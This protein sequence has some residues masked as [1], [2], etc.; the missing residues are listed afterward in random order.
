MR[1]EL[2]PSSLGEILDRTAQM[3]RGHF[4]VYFGIAAVSYAGVLVV[5]L[6]AYTILFAH[7]AG[8]GKQFT[9]DTLFV[10]LGIGLISI[11]P[12]AIGMAAV[13][14]AVASNYLGQT[15]TI[16]QAYSSIRRRWYRYILILVAMYCYAILPA[17]LAMVVTAIPIGVMHTG[18]GR[19]LFIGLM[20]VVVLIGFCAAFWWMLRWALAVPASLMEELAVHRSLK[21]SAMLTKGARGRIFVML[22][23]VVA[24]V[25]VIQYAV[26]I[27]MFFLLF[28]NK[29]AITLATQVVASCGTFLSGSF[30]LPIYSIALTLFYYD[31]RI[32]KEGYDV[33]WLIEQ[34]GAPSDAPFVPAPS[35]NADVK[36]A[37]PDR[38]AGHPP[39]SDSTF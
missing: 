32:R 37:T 22:L 14:R 28:R 16:A 15:V 27:P 13:M 35:P 8:H 2:R 24:V 1:A 23:L 5:S 34:A 3:Y 12:V 7:H 33:E 20:V 30:V 4:L 18:F 25:T 17:I 6:I 21:R 39:V 19:N 38:T 10:G 11:L 9:N 26:Q 31:Q 29:G 36:A